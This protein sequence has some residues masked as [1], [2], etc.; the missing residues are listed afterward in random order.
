MTLINNVLEYFKLPFFSDYKRFFLAK[1]E[2]FGQNCEKYFGA[3][4][5]V[6]ICL[7]YVCTSLTLVTGLFRDEK[8]TD[9]PND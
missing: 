5:I 6:S 1:K 2:Y 4:R 7:I 9:C 3:H 8:F